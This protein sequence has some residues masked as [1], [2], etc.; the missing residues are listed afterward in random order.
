MQLFIRIKDGVPF[1]HPIMED[2]FR[3]AFPEVDPNNL[4]PEFRQFERIPQP[5]H[6]VYEKIVGVTYEMDG[7][8]VKDVWH[9]RDMTPEE[10]LELQNFVKQ[11]WLERSPL[12]SWVFNEEICF[13]EP[14]IPYPTDGNNYEWQEETVSWKMIGGDINNSGSVP[15]VIG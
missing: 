13:F 6:G 2:N 14:P 5:T 15:N 9:V 4:P 7:D 12:K 11:D 1:E 3:E 10:K 8:I